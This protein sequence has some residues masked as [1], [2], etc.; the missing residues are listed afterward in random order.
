MISGHMDY[1]NQRHSYIS[2]TDFSSKNDTSRKK[3]TGRIQKQQ[4]KVQTEIGN[5]MLKI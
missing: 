1:R 3:K 2:N 5:I 4:K